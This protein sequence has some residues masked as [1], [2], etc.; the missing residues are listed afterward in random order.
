LVVK[1]VQGVNDRKLKTQLHAILLLAT[2][3]VS[4]APAGEVDPRF[5][6]KWIGVETLKYRVLRY[7]YYIQSTTVIGIADSGKMFGVLSGFA[8][9]RYEISP[10]SSGR[11]L[12]F[13]VPNTKEDTLVYQGR[14]HCTL[15]LSSDGNTVKEYGNAILSP[16]SHGASLSAE[17]YATFRRQGK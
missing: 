4:A 11:T 10:K 15:T 2:L 7:V 13:Q 5:D 12:I 3:F 16:R 1:S 14:Q 17:V 8:P 9:G 6:G